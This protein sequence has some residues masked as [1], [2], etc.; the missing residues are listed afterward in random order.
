MPYTVKFEVDA[1]DELLKD[2][3][4]TTEKRK[5]VHTPVLV[6]SGIASSILPS[7]SSANSAPQTPATHS[8]PYPGKREKPDP[9]SAEQFFLNARKPSQDA[10]MTL[11]DTVSDRLGAQLIQPRS[12]YLT[13]L[14]SLVVEPKKKVDV[15]PAGLKYNRSSTSLSSAAPPLARSGSASVELGQSRVRSSLLKSY[16][17]FS[18]GNESASSLVFDESV[19]ESQTKLRSRATS[20]PR[21]PRDFESELMEDEEFSGGKELAPYGGFS[22]PDL[23]ES[24][25]KTNVFE[26]APWKI[27][28]SERGNGSLINAMRLTEEKG[29]IDGC[30]WIGAMSLPIDAI[31]TKVLGKIVERLHDEYECENVE[32]DDLTFQG[33][34]KSFCK[35]ILWPTLHY[36]IPD[37][38]KSKAFE[39]H[40]F[41]QYKHLNQKIADRLIEVYEDVNGRRQPNDPEVTIWVHDYHLLL[42]P[43]MIK[44][45]CPQA[46]VGFFLHVSFPSSEVFRCL[47]QRE[48]LL[49][50]I[51]AADSI[52]FQTEEHVRHFLQSCNRLLL[53]D[54]NSNGVIYKE[55]FTL[56][57]TIPVGIDAASL[58]ETLKSDDV[59]EWRQMIRDRWK[60]HSLIVSRDS[61]DKLRGIKQ[62]LL[63]YERFLRENPNLVDHTVLIQIFI[64]TANDEDYKTEVMQIIS[65]INSLPENIYMAQPV[66][67]IHQ[68]IDFDQ[69]LGLLSEA[70]LFIV[71]SMREGMNLTCHEFIVASGEK[72]SPLVLSE[73]TGSSQLLDCDGR[74]ALLVNP[75]DVNSFSVAIKTALEMSKAEK[76]ERWQNCDKIVVTHDSV[77]WVKTCLK[78]ID[79][80]W[81]RDHKRC[82]TNMKPLTQSVF[83][84]FY[85]A[86]RGKRL[87][88][89]NIDSQAKTAIFAGKYHKNTGQSFLE[90]SRTGTILSNVL[91]DKN[92]HVYIA[93]ELPRRELSLLFKN[94]PNVGLIAE[95]G[96][97]IRL[98]GDSKWNSIIEEGS[99]GNWIK[100]VSSLIESKAERLPGSSAIVEDC[101]V[102]LVA[103]YAMEEDPKR[104]L[105]MMGDIIQHI[106]D[107]YGESDQVHATIVQ[108][109][110]VVQ[111]KNISIRALQFVLA[112]HTTDLTLEMLTAKFKIK[113]VVS[114]KEYFIHDEV[115][116]S[117]IKLPTSESRVSLLVFAG[118]LNPIDEEIYDY[119]NNLEKENKID[120]ILTVAVRA[121]MS[122]G[123]T[124]ASYSVLGQNELLTILSKV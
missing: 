21:D 50:G 117:G 82:L 33:H 110:V 75:W 31:P 102:R 124:S 70:E 43:A 7:L 73:F 78:T 84:N 72:K 107:Y 27:V 59:L 54:T 44:K 11:A 113:R 105:D 41:G 30:K 12:R 57:N 80:A 6:K 115:D 39:E 56:V 67:A 112:Y 23:E 91:S 26:H 90:F 35:Q 36:Q 97:Y 48:A 4:L 95:Y 120:D 14:A 58:N 64:G 17:A 99:V 20:T 52:T 66:V 103:D 8:P 5:A 69:Y 55:K 87:F 16:P 10:V 45:K 62:K 123:R 88:I 24:F 89:I 79:D 34:Y 104:T 19:N 49:E 46:K 42:V 29:V 15:G 18:V 37:D 111:K 76:E 25:N 85:H 63:A 60:N 28:R 119:V 122:E 40:S 9:A 96:G 94:T 71:S 98:V 61:M 81:T 121:G 86:S 93:S 100:Q 38:P 83:D 114:S 116:N 118:G 13:P 51:L 101:T 32:V 77:D 92:N 53:A 3:D 74:G 106:N 1:N 47:A 68:D 2:S 108:N 65:R 22:R 109:S